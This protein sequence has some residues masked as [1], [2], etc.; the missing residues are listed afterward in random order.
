MYYYTNGTLNNFTK[1]IIQQFKYIIY[2][3]N[4]NNK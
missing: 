2:Y 3:Y 4:S 1:L